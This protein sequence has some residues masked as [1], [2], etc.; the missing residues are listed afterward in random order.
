MFRKISLLIIALIGVSTGVFAQRDGN[1]PSGI[2]GKVLDSTNKAIPGSVVM[3]I[4]KSD[5]TKTLGTGTNANG[6]FKLTPTSNGDYI[7]RIKSLGYETVEKQVKYIGNPVF[8]GNTILYPVSYQTGAANINGNIPMI[9][10][11]DTAE[12]N[13]G[14][15]KVN[16]DATAED[17]VT[18]MPGI[19]LQNGKV[20]AQGEDVK[21]VLVDGKPMMG[22]DPS[23]ALKNLPAEMVDKVQVFDQKSDQAQF[24]G[25]DDGNTN[26]TINIVTKSAYK[27]GYFGKVYAGAGSKNTSDITNN[28][29]YK[30]G[31]SA[32]FFKGERRITLLLNSN[33]INEQNFAISDIMGMMG[34]GGGGGGMRMMGGG[35]GGGNDPSS[36]FVNQKAGINTTNAGG[37]NYANKWKKVDLSGSY[38]VN[39]TDNQTAS[40]TVRN[41]V[42][43]SDSVQLLYKEN[44]ASTSTNRNH[45]ANLR[46]EWKV[47][48]VNSIVFTPRI[49]YQE[50]LGN[51]NTSGANL[52]NSIISSTTQYSNR[53]QTAG[54]NYAIPVLYR[55][56]FAKKGRTVSINV[57]PSFN[58][59][60]GTTDIA[61]LQSS[62]Y[63]GGIRTNYLYQDQQ[64][65]AKGNSWSNNVTFTEQLG[66][67]KQL[68]LTYSNSLNY[69]FSDKHTFSSID[70]SAL[71]L[72]DTSLTNVFNS[73]YQS[74]SVGASLRYA[75][76]KVNM[77]VGLTAQTANLSNQID[78]PKAD[79]VDRTFQSILPSANV[80]I[81]LNKRRNLR[82][83]YRSNN[84]VPSVSQLQ[85][86]INFTNPLQVSIGNP[87]LK[88]DWSN[89][90]NV[91][92]GSTNLEKNR[93]F[94]GM[95]NISFTR[96]YIANG[97]Y[98]LQND[99]T[100]G[101][102][103]V[104]RKGAQISA[105]VNLNG[106]YA[107]R[108]FGNYSF[109]FAKNKLNFN[110]MGSANYSRTPGIVNN[111][112]NFA[113]SYSGMLGAGFTSNISEFFDFSL[114]TNGTYNAIRNTLQA[115]LNS[116]YFNLTTRFKVQYILKKKVV[117]ATDLSHNY[118]TGLSSSINTSFLLWNASVGYKFMKNQ[119][120]EFRLTVFDILKQNNSV[121]RNTTE[122]YW[123][124]VRS[125]VLTRYA[126]L[127]FT[128]NFRKF[129]SGNSPTMEFQMPRHMPPMGP[130]GFGPPG[131]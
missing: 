101:S 119:A 74:H 40:E 52:L 22:D 18:K 99:S 106:Y 56:Q 87:N 65:Q 108:S 78:F 21:K 37:L 125:M 86:V 48:S 118:N 114:Y 41:Y 62:E 126:M 49:T 83:N 46:L 66:Q 67:Y 42:T 50:Y 6:F 26:K 122:I 19:T 3:L 71:K 43:S 90:L 2:V 112:N 31:R 104:L 89:N 4:L 14:S 121:S 58:N 32:N 27:N 128:Y 7:V 131:G 60:N 96:N 107:I 44:A 61:N 51:A 129:K 33:N 15:F 105:P 100:F 73:N 109:P 36:F 57:S 97:T 54:F 53:P 116:N 11:G 17:L 127:T 92:Y 68:S 45:R 23:A 16:K 85:N 81:K 75:K 39:Y 111:R 110:L 38:F 103:V 124:D 120:G 113:N 123:E 25:F 8:L 5:T 130:G 20:Q 115:S 82:F 59:S 34:G 24:T 63:M 72:M 29:V 94:F 9:M 69:N 12:M 93:S 1:G 10:K 88:Q 64:I 30:A 80:Q 77:N 13:A 91:R 47:D 84:N 79:H 98:I 95:A 55:H 35:G 28:Y 76:N 102:D 117:F 70:P